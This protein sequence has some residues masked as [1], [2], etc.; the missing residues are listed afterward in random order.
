MST[1]QRAGPFHINQEMPW[2]FAYK[3]GGIFL[4]S[5]FPHITFFVES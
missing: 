1:A 3:H 4:I 2:R 5:L